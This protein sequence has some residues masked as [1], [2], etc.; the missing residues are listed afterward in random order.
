[1]L[2]DYEFPYNLNGTEYI[3]QVVFPKE[4]CGYNIP[5]ILVMPKVLNDN[6]L[7]SVEVNNLETDSQE[8]LINNGLLTARHL[9]KTLEGLNSP[10]LVP[11]IPSVK[12]GIPYFQQL[13]KE[14]FELSSNE[15]LYRIDLQVKNIIEEVKAKIS[16]KVD[17]NDKIFLNGYSASGVF[18]QRF[19][20]LHPELIDTLCVGGA[21]GSI[22]IPNNQLEYPLGIKDIVNITGVNF[23][24]DDYLKI[25]FRYY[26]GSLEDKRKSSRKDEF[27]EFAPM[28][29]MSYFERSVPSQVGLLQRKLF[30]KNIFE[31]AKAE[32]EI[33]QKLGIDITQIIFEGR[34]HNNYN[35]VGVNELGDEFIRELYQETLNHTKNL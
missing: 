12:G 3:V 29:D 14:C 34:T 13:S 4:N 22:P 26:V 19:A 9:A 15:V 18:A 7:L 16:T 10:I 30:G 2:S 33:M 31:R 17:I 28:H 5:Y 20:L 23:N 32:I 8:E 1:M 25:K 11:I 21:S 24:Y 35:G 6:T 27:G